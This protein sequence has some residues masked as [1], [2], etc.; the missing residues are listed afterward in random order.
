MKQL[1]TLLLMIALI[2]ISCKKEVIED[3]VVEVV[4]A[5]GHLE[6]NFLCEKEY[7]MYYSNGAVEFADIV[8]NF[9][10]IGNTLKMQQYEFEIDSDTQTQFTSTN[11]TTGET[12]SLTFT[13]NFQN[14]ILNWDAPSYLGGPSYTTDYIGFRS[15]L[16]ASNS[17]GS[18][19]PHPY[20]SDMEGQ[21]IMT[22][23]QINTFTGLDTNFVDTLGVTMTND[24]TFSVGGSSLIFGRFHSHSNI[25]NSD[26]DNDG[27]IIRNIVHTNTTLHLEYR[28]VAGAFTSPTDSII[29][30]YDGVKL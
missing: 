10:V 25:I 24:H 7:H 14:V 23:T 20:K 3:P 28:E 12:T 5:H 11:A 6:G 13:D 1:L 9:E 22:T 4:P 15:T 19:L 27:R 17:Y 8:L 16:L 30:L 29:T 26:Y 21:Y 18:S 2:T